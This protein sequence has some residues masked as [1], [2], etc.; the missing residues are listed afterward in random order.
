MQ[1]LTRALMLM[2]VTLNAV[3]CATSQSIAPQSREAN[4]TG[5]IS[6]RA[7]I[8]GKPA[9]NIPISVTPDPQTGARER[10]VAS[11]TTDGEGRFQLTHVPAG[12]FYVAAFAP[13]F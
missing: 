9:A 11:S 6:G 3:A 2:A 13:A 7:T 8:D 5:A 4:A 10:L 1:T 12:R